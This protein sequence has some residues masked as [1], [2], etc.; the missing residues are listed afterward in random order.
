MAFLSP[1]T[2]VSGEN[3]HDRC[4]LLRASQIVTAEPPNSVTL[5]TFIKRDGRRIYNKKARVR[6]LLITQQCGVFV[7]PF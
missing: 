7:Q 5:S 1:F 3:P 4:L 2:Q 6:H